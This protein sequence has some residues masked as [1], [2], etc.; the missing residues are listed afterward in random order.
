MVT[1]I[2]MLLVYTFVFGTIFKARW[3]VSSL[4][5]GEFALALFT[6][7]LTF[8]IFAESANRAPGL[9]VANQSLVKKVVFPLSVLPVMVVM[10]AMVQAVISLGVLLVGCLVIQGTLHWTVVFIPVVLAPVVIF[11]LGFSWLL[12]SVG[13]FLRD[14]GQGIVI[15]TTTLMFLTPIFYPVEALPE[16]YRA[17]AAASP[18]AVAVENMRLIV[19][20]GKQPDWIGIMIG[21]AS[22][23]VMAAIGWL[24]F[25]K[26]RKGFADVL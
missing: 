8:N 26:T 17:I 21:L 6:G 18:I 1:P 9:I 13:V 14:I 23:M 2:L 20:W 15:V 19:L 16:Q 3:G 12:S 10:S 22:S 4:S 11:A 5:S 7:L 24:W 25:A